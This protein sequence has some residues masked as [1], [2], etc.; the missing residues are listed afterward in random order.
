MNKSML[1][2]SKDKSEKQKTTLYID[3]SKKFDKYKNPNG[4]N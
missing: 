2:K 3:D 1:I 4:C